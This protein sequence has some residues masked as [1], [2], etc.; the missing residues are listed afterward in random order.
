MKR[1]TMMIKIKLNPIHKLY[2]KYKKVR[3]KWKMIISDTF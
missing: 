2:K 1:T 3:I